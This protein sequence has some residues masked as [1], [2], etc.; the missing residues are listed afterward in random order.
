[1]DL[2]GSISAGSDGVAIIRFYPCAAGFERLQ[3]LHTQILQAASNRQVSPNAKYTPILCDVSCVEAEMAAS[4]AAGS[5]FTHQRP[6]DRSPSPLSA[7]S[8]HHRT[9]TGGN[10]IMKPTPMAVLMTILPK[11]QP[12]DLA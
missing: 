1:M 7:A 2:L 11:N 4:Y 3:K 12:M 6:N 8:L 9:Q 5:H 10:V